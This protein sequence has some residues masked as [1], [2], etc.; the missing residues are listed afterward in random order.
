MLA[1]LFLS[2]LTLPLIDCRLPGN[3]GGMRVSDFLALIVGAIF[4]GKYCYQSLIKR[5]LQPIV[6]PLGWYWF[7]FL[8]AILISSALG[9]W[10]IES[11]KYSLKTIVFAYLF[12][13]VV[14]ANLVNTWQKWR[15]LL[16]GVIIAGIGSGLVGLW[17]LTQQDLNNVFFRVQPASLWG[18]WWLGYNHNLIAEF[19][20]IS[21]MFLLAAR[22]LIKNKIGQRWLDVVFFCC[23]ILTLLTFSRAAWI[24]TALQLVIW[25]CFLKNSR[26]KIG[27]LL[28]S[29]ILVIIALPLWLRM[30]NL[31][32]SNFSSTENRA[33]LLQISVNNFL[34]HPL[35]GLGSGQYLRMVGDNLRFV[36]K[37]GDPIDS[38][39]V[40]QKLIAE[41]GLIGLLTYFILFF[42]LIKYWLKLWRNNQSS[43]AWVI[44]LI[45][46]AFGGLFFQFF[47]TSYYKGRV[48][49]PVA[50]TLIAGQLIKYDK[51]RK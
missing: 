14:P 8:A 3:W 30:E 23:L 41:N 29:G 24:T 25:W 21:N 9:A 49:L 39:G 4:A 28:A 51:E 50:L 43:A 34:E 22:G 46:G 18:H 16:W 1:G 26:Q 6:W 36:A 20:V 12:Y 47:N 38:H 11:I 27:W 48:W 31:Q 5:K 33:L 10:P 7:F 17:S 32:V 44:P 40:I 42:A 37:Y 13:I 15:W 2:A 19:L 45:L 35:V